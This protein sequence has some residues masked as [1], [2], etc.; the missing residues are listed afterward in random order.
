MLSFVTWKSENARTGN[1]YELNRTATLRYYYLINKYIVRLTSF[2]WDF[3]SSISSGVKLAIDIDFTRWG[4]VNPRLQKKNT[5]K[6]GHKFSAHVQLNAT[7]IYMHHK[8]NWQNCIGCKYT[9]KC[10]QCANGNEWHYRKMKFDASAP[11]LIPVIV[12]F[13]EIEIAVLNH[14]NFFL[15]FDIFE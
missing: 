9:K 4:G 11:I 14:L 8:W 7:A 3:S 12:L 10:G 13:I 1:T 15:L 5:S 2:P 6:Q